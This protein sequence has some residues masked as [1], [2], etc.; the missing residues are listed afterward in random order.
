MDFG[1]S[2]SFFASRRLMHFVPLCST[3]YKELLASKGNLPPS[4][5]IPGHTFACGRIDLQLRL[6]TLFALFL[7]ITLVD[8][9]NVSCL[10]AAGSFGLR[11]FNSCQCHLEFW[12][13]NGC[14]PATSLPTLM[15]RYWTSSLTLLTHL[16]PQHFTLRFR[17]LNSRLDMTRHSG[18]TKK[19]PP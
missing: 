16:N 4:M 5:Q 14:G 17:T 11:Q 8:D 7:H 19:L 9:D 18:R 15:M 6:H 13:S 12:A 2:P 1:R 3:L 10:V